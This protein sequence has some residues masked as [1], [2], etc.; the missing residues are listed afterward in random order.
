MY[1]YLAF[2]NDL[3]LAHYLQILPRHTFVCQAWATIIRTSVSAALLDL[4][5]SFKHVCQPDA[6]FK[7]TCPRS[8]NTSLN[9]AVI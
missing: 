5:M 9:R 6:I 1:Q 3:K 4:H 8:R 7:F 2:R